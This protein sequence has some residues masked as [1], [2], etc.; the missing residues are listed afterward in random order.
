MLSTVAFCSVLFDFQGLWVSLLPDDMQAELHTQWGFDPWDT[1]VQDVMANAVGAAAEGDTGAA[2]HAM[3]TAEK[4]YDSL[5][6]D[7]IATE[8]DNCVDL[9]RILAAQ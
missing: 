8:M 5:S 2:L 7:E 4:G 1:A 3:N 6:P 9:Y